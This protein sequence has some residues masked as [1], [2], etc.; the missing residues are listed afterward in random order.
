MASITPTPQED[1][2]LTVATLH[3]ASSAVNSETYSRQTHQR[4]W[5]LW[6]LVPL[7]PYGNRQTLCTEVIPGQV[8]TFDQL[9]G[10]FYVVVPIRMTVIKLSTGGLLVYAPVAPTKECITQMRQLTAVH[11]DVKY[12]ILPTVSGLEHKV[13]VGPF[14]RKFP[15]AQVYVSPNQWSFPVNLPLTW[16]GLPLGRTHKLPQHSQDAPFSLDFDYAQL[17]PID[18]GVGP[19]EEIAFFH[20]RSRSLILTDSI[21]SIPAQPPAVLVREP[22]P[23]LFHARE[24]GVEPIE[25]TAAN[26]LKGWKRIALFAMYFQPHALEIPAWGNVLKEALKGGDRSKQG[27]FGLYPFR[28]RD[29]WEQSFDQ[30]HGNGRLFVAPI[31]QQLIFNRDP[32]DVLEWRDRVCQWDIQRII[33]CHFDCPIAATPT[34]LYQAF[35][36]LE[37]GTTQQPI[38]GT[39][40]GGLPIE[41]LFTMKQ[42]DNRLNQLGI[43]RLPKC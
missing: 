33:P 24:T 17:G 3:Q 32:K 6:P 5:P 27:Y 41:D 43:T 37:T 21:V 23:M 13:F 36:F 1:N 20:K 30:L 7:Y 14:A 29:D 42:L 26:R 12:I 16:L 25:D 39:Q 2:S 8:W 4:S 18:L 28:W 19:F 22:Y 38:P 11:G 34:E 40:Q 35:M 15:Q 9:Q 10:I 31:L